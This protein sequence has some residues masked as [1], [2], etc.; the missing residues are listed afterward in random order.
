[1]NKIDTFS[2]ITRPLAVSALLYGKASCASFKR[3]VVETRP[4]VRTGEPLFSSGK[5]SMALSRP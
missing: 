5:C 3:L 1:M 2:F 4:Y